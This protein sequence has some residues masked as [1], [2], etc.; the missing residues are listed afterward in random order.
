MIIFCLA[1]AVMR[2]PRMP[3][4]DTSYR[5]LYLHADLSKQPELDKSIKTIDEAAH[6]GYN[7]VVFE[8]PQMESGP[9]VT[10]AYNTALQSVV[11][12]AK[13]Q[14]IEL[15][16]AI[17]PIGSPD[18]F[19]A[20][21]PSLAES[22][23]CRNVRYTVTNGVMKGSDPA[24]PIVNGTFDAFTGEVPNG[25][26][27]T[28]QQDV[29]VGPDTAVKHGGASSLRVDGQPTSKAGQ[30]GVTYK[31]T[32]VLR[33]W[34]QY[35]ISVWT[36]ANNSAGAALNLSILSATGHPIAFLDWNNTPDWT[37]NDLI[38]NSQ[39]DGSTTLSIV[40]QPL[41]NSQIWIDDLTLEDVG[42]LNITRRANCPVIIH[43]DDGVIYREVTD[44]NKLI[45]PFYP[46]GAFSGIYDI[47]HPAPTP[48]VSPLSRIHEGQ[49]VLLDFY[50]PIIVG[51]RATICPSESKTRAAL[52]SEIQKVIGLIHPHTVLLNVSN[53]RSLG[54]DPGC[55]ASGMTAGEI[56]AK[57]MRDE[58]ILVHSFDKTIQIATFSDM[59]DPN[60]NAL[61]QFFLM[62]GSATDSI[63][64]VSKDTL[65]LNCNYL[66]PTESLGFF[67]GQGYTQ[68]LWGFNDNVNPTIPIADWEKIASSLQG[69]KGFAYATTAGD[70][71]HLAD[72]KKSATDA[73]K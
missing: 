47:V 33:P 28:H 64:G 2:H 34:H 19:L 41:P 72:F 15:I 26:T 66:H 55:E 29:K 48:T 6:V 30:G 43:G 1:A 9:T 16:P 67:A 44:L 52:R 51:G 42:F 70:Y 69:I 40:V 71:S 60:G 50:A 8:D 21:D 63:D 31:Q 68:I 23:P 57:F 7:G 11:T 39:D 12:E 49:T 18:A 38:F 35:R 56:I 32:L 73:A 45:D 25:F 3:V 58:T 59:F 22:M 5:W 62:K 20:R 65:I 14:N 24:I 53:V 17:A 46:S 13:K 37:K 61:D 54:W 4:I 27:A 10:P 36:K